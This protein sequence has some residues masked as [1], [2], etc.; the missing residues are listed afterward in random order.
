MR[1]HFS[2]AP[3]RFVNG[4]FDSDAPVTRNRNTFHLVVGS[5]PEQFLE[6]KQPIR[7]HLVRPKRVSRVL[8][9]TEYSVHT[10]FSPRQLHSSVVTLKPTSSFSVASTAHRGL[11]QKCKNGSQSLDLRPGGSHMLTPASWHVGVGAV[12][13]RHV[14][15]EVSSTSR[16]NHSSASTERFHSTTYV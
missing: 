8:V 6:M 3:C 10:C 9:F 11:I 14:M 5:S 7:T 2:S 1:N 15:G 12:L 4:P 13:A 16:A